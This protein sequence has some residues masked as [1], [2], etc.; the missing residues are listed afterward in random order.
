MNNPI[1]DEEDLKKIFK[2][3]KKKNRF[4]ELLKFSRSLTKFFLLFLFF[5][6]IVNFPAYWKQIDYLFKTNILKNGYKN[7]NIN[8]T[9]LAKNTPSD[10]QL[11][12]LKKQKEEEMLIEVKKAFD[13]QLASLIGENQIIVPKISLK[14]PIVWNSDSKNIL[15]DLKKG[16]AHYKGTGLP[17]QSKSNIFIT[18]HSSNFIWDDGKY[19]Q[20]FAL[21]DKLENSDRIYLVYNN[22]PYIFSV[23]AKRVVSPKSVEVL[24]PQDHSLV[25][26]MTCYPVGT[27]LNRMIVQARQIYPSENSNNNFEIPN[28]LLSN[29]L[30]VI[31]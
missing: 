8:L 3:P 2:M 16:V 21:I 30:P 11:D 15:S 27:T 4:F 5:F 24:N 1:L 17:G 6:I 29:Q 7:R 31:R 23:E 28:E 10:K 13:I 25:S 14:A 22:N 18:G 9:S 26:L 20:V 12:Q 19:K